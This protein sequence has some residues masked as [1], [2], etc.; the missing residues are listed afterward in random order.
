MTHDRRYQ[1]RGP[2]WAPEPRP[3]RWRGVLEAAILFGVICACAV[4]SIR[5]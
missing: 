3:S 2:N 5:W 4:D 1:A